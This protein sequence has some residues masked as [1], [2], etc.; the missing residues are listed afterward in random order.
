MRY[1]L[2][3]LVAV[4]VLSL[5]VRYFADPVRL[6]Q[7]S[8]DPARDL[9]EMAAR[10]PLLQRGLGRADEGD[11]TEL[12]TWLNRADPLTRQRLA[13]LLLRLVAPSGAGQ[14]GE[15]DPALCWRH[16]HRFRAFVNLGTGREAL[17]T[18]IDNLVAYTLVTGGSGPSTQDLAIAKQLLPRL[19]RAA[20]ES[21]DDAIMDTV[22]CVQ[23]AAGDYATAK[24]S[25]RI[26][27][28]YAGQGRD[29]ERTARQPLYTRRQQA[30]ERNAALKAAAVPGDQPDYEP[31][32]PDVVVA[33]ATEP[34]PPVTA[35]KEPVKAEAAPVEPSAP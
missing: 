22:G 15:T 29:Q 3:L 35:E 30:A 31:L 32:P 2:I 20:Q 27:G 1:S 8:P 34:T 4:M 11:V 26:A 19:K 24:E 17:D 14:S 23:F 9:H 18:A 5:G 28:E 16:R 13:F 25:F 10:D 21:S 7:A 6:A 33:A 12:S